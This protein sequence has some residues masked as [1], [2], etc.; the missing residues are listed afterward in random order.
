LR[1]EVRAVSKGVSYVAATGMLGTGYLEESLRAGLERGARFVGC[2]S[3][4][5]D[6]GPN[7]LGTGNPLFGREAYKRDLRVMLTAARDHGV[8]VLVG[9]AGGAGSR[10]QLAWMRDIVEEIARE[11]DLHFRLAVIDSEQDPAY[12][13]ARHAE[14]RVK[15][16]G[17]AELTADAIR[18]CS[19][20]VAALGAEPFQAALDGGA[21]VVL[22][23]RSTDASIYAALP[24]HH[25]IA[26]GPVWHAGKTSECGA[27][28]VV[29]R[30][31]PDSL[32]CAVDDDGFTVTPLNPQMRCT[33]GS[34]A[35]HCLYENRDPY[36]VKEPSGT[37]D[38]SASEYTAVDERTV[39][40][41]G[42][43]FI[44]ADR[45]TVKLEGAKLAGYQTI[46]LGGVRDPVILAQLDD[47]LRT[48]EER[49]HAR[50]EQIYGGSPEGGYSFNLRVYGR[51]GVLGDR[52]PVKEVGHEVCVLF[53]MTA[54]TQEIATT[55]ALSAA[56]IALHNPIDNWSG[57]I[58]T[59]AFPYAPHHIERGPVYEFAMNHVLE[60]DDPLEPC[61]LDFVNV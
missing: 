23:G 41:T 52:E 60:L 25:G 13:I 11:N 20:I 9:S 50:S 51:D 12:V 45:Y 35:S 6:D 44:P 32:F 31:H 33:P 18:S 17:T 24:L 14:G 5:V 1:A 48:L 40:V 36:I 59:L 7:Q 26:P 8:P 56:H 47:W 55:L 2:D 49:V 16:L 53:D 34:V 29:Y 3:G 10:S 4:S 58:S 42:S 54:A 46:V 37:I 61:V 39:R 30:T 28:P 15:A 19:H 22:A 57:L 43:R 38:T 27:A 21:D